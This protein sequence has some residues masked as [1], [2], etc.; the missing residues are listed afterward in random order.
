MGNHDSKRSRIEDSLDRCRIVSRRPHDRG[1]GRGIA[2]RL[3][4]S[5]QRIEV[6]RG[7][8][9]I[10]NKPVEFRLRENLGGDMT[11]ELQ[12]GAAS[13]FPGLQPRFQRAGNFGAVGLRLQPFF[14]NA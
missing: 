4:L 10:D 1:A 9:H 13:D 14:A 11:A 7:V 12:K 3:Q 2:D 6:N 5:Q 8:L